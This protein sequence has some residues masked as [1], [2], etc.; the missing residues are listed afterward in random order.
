MDDCG[1]CHGTDAFGTTEQ[2]AAKLNGGVLVG[3]KDPNTSECG[4][5]RE[6]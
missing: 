4:A 2:A 3:L 5:C 6:P 1:W